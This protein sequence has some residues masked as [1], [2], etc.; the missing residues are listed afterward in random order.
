MGVLLGISVCVWTMIVHALGWYTT[1]LKWGQRADVAATVLPVLAIGLAIAE[2]RRVN[3]RQTL[4]MVQGIGTGLLAG[5]VS[6][7]ITAAFLWFYHHVINPAWLDHLITYERSKLAAAGA[8]A[9]AIAQKVD[10]LVQSGRDASQLIGAL[11]GTTILSLVLAVLFSA[12]FRRSRPIGR[13][14]LEGVA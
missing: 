8:S 12:A 7:P 6:I 2:R 13:P 10:G 5:L 3:A 1:N 11:V 4:T 9:A 14:S